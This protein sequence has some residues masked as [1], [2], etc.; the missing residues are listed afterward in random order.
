MAGCAAAG[1]IV[2]GAAGFAALGAVVFLS[3]IG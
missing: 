3:V 2:T 1:V